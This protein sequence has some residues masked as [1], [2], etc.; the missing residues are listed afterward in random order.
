MRASAFQRLS[1]ED[2]AILDLESRTIAGHTCKLIVLGPSSRPGA[3]LE[4]L[5]RQIAGRL[6]DAPRLRERLVATPLGVA[7]PVWI[8]DP[9]FDVANHVLPLASRGPIDRRELPEL[10]AMLMR[11]RLD[12]TRPLW[13]LHV[14]E[15][16]DGDAALIWRIHHCM[17]DG[18]AALR[19]AA[20]ML[21]DGE[22]DTTDTLA[23]AEWNPRP[24]PGW[25]QLLVAGVK[26]RLRRLA[27]WRPPVLRAAAK[28]GPRRT[29]AT[30]RRELSPGNDRSPFDARRLSSERAVAFA[31]APLSD[32]KGIGRGIGRG[33]TVNDVLLALIAGGLRYWMTADSRVPVSLRA[34]VPVSLHDHDQLA[35]RDSF[36]CIELPLEEA[37]P[38][39]RIRLI[40]DATSMRKSQHDAQALDAVFGGRSRVPVPMERFLQR[41]ADD[42]R[43]A[44]LCV[45]NVPGPRG[46]IFVAGARV[47]E[48]YTV[49]EIGERHALRV[50]AVSLG[51]VLSLGFCADPTAV[52]H[53]RIVVEG[54]QRE[55]ETLRACV[56]AD[57]AS[58]GQ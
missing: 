30:I 37:E 3:R 18:T 10:V 11:G 13:S 34:K 48:L 56:G 45:S 53:L 20:Q 38:A 27:H 16:K 25:Y 47:R 33:A 21:W 22:Q 7:A 40:H 49:A 23:A 17:A 52:P 55:L 1:E 44:A 32:L 24:I 42:P 5:R 12:R 51:D 15:L 35:N 36:F 54:V 41:R 50:S 9:R 2:R 29:V 43:V 8:E 39:E 6:A 58:G 19:L 31:S 46:P 28:G 57:T 4:I 14:A 26:D